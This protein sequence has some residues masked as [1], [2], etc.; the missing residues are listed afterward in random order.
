M[1]LKRNDRIEVKN[2]KSK[3]CKNEHLNIV[4]ND[5]PLDVWLDQKLPGKDLLGLVPTMSGWIN[6]SEEIEFLRRRYVQQK[7]VLPILMCPDDWDECGLV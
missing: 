4:I 2:M 6:Q 3:Y 1:E 5:I 7:G